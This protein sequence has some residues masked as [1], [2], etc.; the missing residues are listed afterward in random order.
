MVDLIIKDILPGVLE[1]VL[2]ISFGI[3]LGWI[4][5][6]A[7]AVRFLGRLAAPVIRFAKL[8][9]VCASSFVISIA[10]QKAAGAMLSSAYSNKEISRRSLI[11]GAA[12]NSFPGALIKL[13]VAAPLLIATL[14]VAGIAYVAFTVAGSALVLAVVMAGGRI[15][16]RSEHDLVI[17]Q[18][19]SGENPAAKEKTSW[20]IAWQRWRQLLPKVLAVAVPVYTIVAILNEK[21]VFSKLATKFPPQLEGFLPP[22]AMAVM[23]MQMASTTRA[24]PVAK[25]FI[26]SGALTPAALFFALV[27]GYVVSLPLRVVRRNL[28][29]ALSLYPGRNGVWIIVISQV[30]RFLLGLALLT[31]WFLIQMRS[32]P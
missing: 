18:G 15:W 8:P 4:L 19:A 1:L 21:G 14:G 9:S 2:L 22:E 31:V 20:R 17:E 28:P 6:A 30:P 16:R 32:M 10:S 5:E 23:V 3:L 24:V 11:L 26:D 29:S 27:A 25:K 7:G 13:R 12:A